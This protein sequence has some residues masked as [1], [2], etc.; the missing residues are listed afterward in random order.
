MKPT[1][2]EIRN[3]T[4]EDLADVKAIADGLREQLGFV[5]R[6][7]ISRSIERN[8]LLVAVKDN[9]IIGF[10]DYHIRRDKQLTLYHIAVNPAWQRQGVGRVLLDTLE[11][12]AG[13]EDCSF[14]LLKCPVDLAANR[15]YKE[16]GYDLV[17]TLNGRKRPL[18][19]WK[20][21]LDKWK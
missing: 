9:R 21:D 15:F 13:G 4:P 16:Q 6:A 10:V 19:V 5:N 18:N 12:L 14:I 17:E 3:S 1:S 2:L 20:S 7:G 11:R 8:E